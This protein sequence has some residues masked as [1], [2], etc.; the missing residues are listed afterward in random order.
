[1]Q[2]RNLVACGLQLQLVQQEPLKKVL[3]TIPLAFVVQLNG[4]EIRLDK[5]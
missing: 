3:V 1:M 5:L 2:C 4:K